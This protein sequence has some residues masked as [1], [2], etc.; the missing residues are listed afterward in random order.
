MDLTNLLALH[1]FALMLVWVPFVAIQ[2]AINLVTERDARAGAPR[3]R[4]THHGYTLRGRQ[5]AHH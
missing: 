3:S 4:G 2:G 1:A 5:L